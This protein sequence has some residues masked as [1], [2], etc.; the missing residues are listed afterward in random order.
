MEKVENA[1]SQNDIVKVLEICIENEFYNLGYFI[2]FNY[3]LEFSN[4]SDYTEKM[5]FIKSFL[6]SEKKEN[7]L[8]SKIR[9]NNKAGNKANLKKIKLFCHWTTSKSLCDTWNK[10]SKGNYTWNDIK[11]VWGDDYDYLVIINAPLYIDNQFQFES[12]KDENFDKEK[13][14]VFIMEPLMEK[15][16]SVWGKWSD[17]SL[18]GY[19]NYYNHINSYNINEWHIS[20][21]FSELLETDFQSLKTK[22]TEI[23]VI[24]SEKYV[25]P[26]HIKRIDFIKFLEE[27]EDVITDVYGNNKF[28]YKN[29]KGSLPI[30]KKD[31]GLIPY[32][33]SF[34]VENMFVENYFTEKIIDSIVSESLVFYHGCPNIKDFIDE[35]AFVWLELSNFEQDYLL[36]KKAISENWYEQRLPFIKEMKKK[37]IN[38]MQFFPR[39]EK[40]IKSVE[41][42]K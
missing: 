42:R 14:F 1:L 29:Y 12:K 27:K 20:K 17:V 7:Q 40:I 4:N 2:G 21:T 15:H 18:L 41:K 26:G 34:N 22:E 11:I 5:S 10:M 16:P 39:L 38:E 13:T 30:H 8:V 31:E 24:L 9:F 36:I 3:Y 6:F 25:D 28:H 19:P 37:I 33:Y 23:S 35:R 32:K